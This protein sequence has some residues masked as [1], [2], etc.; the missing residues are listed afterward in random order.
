MRYRRLRQVLFFLLSIGVLSS[1]KYDEGPILSL[2][3]KK[4]RVA[5]EWKVEKV[6]EANGT[7]REGRDDHW[8]FTK[9]GA[10]F[11]NGNE[12]GRWEFGSDKES[13]ILEQKP[14]PDEE[15]EI[16]RLKE[17]EMWLESEDDEEIRF[18]AK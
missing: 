10:L 4:E 6:I 7:E 15:F 13:L 9:D 11:V 8:T 16:L 3:A 2:R 5:N 17:Q 12:K 1:C 14:G 18:E